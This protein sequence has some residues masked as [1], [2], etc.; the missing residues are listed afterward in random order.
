MISRSFDTRLDTPWWLVCEQIRFSVFWK[1]PFQSRPRP[2]VPS[3]HI[4][5]HNPSHC[6]TPPPSSL[7]PLWKWILPQNTDCLST[8]QKIKDMASAINVSRATWF[9]ED[10][11]FHLIDLRVGTVQGLLR[12]PWVTSSSRWHCIVSQMLLF[13]WQLEL[14]HNH[15]ALLLW[16]CAV[17]ACMY[18]SMPCARCESLIWCSLCRVSPRNSFEM[19]TTRYLTDQQAPAR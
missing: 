17:P 4:V 7:W 8:D 16:S 6:S 9:P 3:P 5:P 10:I 11:V 13:I 14:G 18:K 19:W 2:K 1:S 12:R 15:C